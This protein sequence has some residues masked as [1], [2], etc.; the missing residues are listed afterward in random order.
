MVTE[1]YNYETDRE[2]RRL[3][4]LSIYYEAMSQFPNP[5]GISGY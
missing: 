4:L 3:K 2:I 1:Q 5:F